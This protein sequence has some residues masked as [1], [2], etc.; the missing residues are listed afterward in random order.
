MS[1]RSIRLY[2]TVAGTI[3]LGT[4]VTVFLAPLAYSVWLAHASA[5][6]PSAGGTILESGTRQMKHRGSVRIYPSVKY[7]YTVGGAAYEGET[8]Q[9]SSE[10]AGEAQAQE[11][12]QR[13]RPGPVQVYYDPNNPSESV[14]QPGGAV[15]I[16][17]FMLVGGSVIFGGG[18]FMLL[19][20]RRALKPASCPRERGL[21]VESGQ[22]QLLRRLRQC[23]H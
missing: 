22:F 10:Y 13:F 15:R 7:S 4:L 16:Q 6:W 18:L 17:W 20:V 5:T 8:I 23:R 14:L 3:S 9:L 12:A 11:I 19:L 2:I 1:P 21:S